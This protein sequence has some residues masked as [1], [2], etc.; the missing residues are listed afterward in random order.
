MAIHIYYTK[1]D[2]NNNVDGIVIEED[3]TIGV[4]KV[5]IPYI[6]WPTVW[7]NKE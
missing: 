4:V 3:M 7:F 1:G 5:K 2:A 6:G